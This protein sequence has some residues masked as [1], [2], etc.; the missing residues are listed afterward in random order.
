MARQSLSRLYLRNC[1]MLILREVV[2]KCIWLGSVLVGKCIC[3]K[4]WYE[5]DFPFALSVV[6][7]NW[8]I[9]SGL[10]LINHKV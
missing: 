4:S 9:L 6:T 3:V 5:L 1:E 2:G 10:Y 8:K 7:L